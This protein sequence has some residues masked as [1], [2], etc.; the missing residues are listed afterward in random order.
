MSSIEAAPFAGPLRGFLSWILSR[1]YL[2]T[3]SHQAALSCCCCCCGGCGQDVSSAATARIYIP[4]EDGKK[5]PISIPALE[6]KIVRRAAVKLLSAI[7][8]QDFLDCSYGFRPGRGAHGAL[9]EVGRTSNGAGDRSVESLGVKAPDGR[10]YRS[11][12]RRGA[13]NLAGRGKCVNWEGP[14]DV[15]RAKRIAGKTG[16]AQPLQISAKA[17]SAIDVLDHTRIELPGVIESGMPRRNGQRK[18]GTT[19]GSPSTSIP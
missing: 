12:P 14:K 15:P 4:K 1:S 17:M 3:L 8:E 6:D 19:C 7:Y 18:L 2:L 10:A 11:D 16:S 5:R 13:S 9:D